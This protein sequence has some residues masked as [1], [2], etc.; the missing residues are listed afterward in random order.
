VFA[1]YHINHKSGISG[2]DAQQMVDITERQSDPTFRLLSYRALGSVQYFT[3][4]HRQALDT[5]RL[6]EGYRDPSKLNLPS[7]RFG[8]DP[9]LAVL[10]YK[11][12]ALME[13]GLLDQAK[14]VAEQVKV[15]L[16]DHAHPPTIAACTFF[17]VV[18]PE[19]LSGKAEECEQHSADL[20]AYCTKKKVA[21]F[22]L[23]AKLSLAC[24]RSMLKPT[25]ESIAAFRDAIKA[26]HATGAHLGD[27]F[28]FSNLAAALLKAGAVSEAAQTLQ[29]AFDFVERSGE[30]WWL[31]ELYR[32][33]G[34]V[35]LTQAEP[36]M[37][38]AEVAFLKAI[39]TA[40]QQE[41]RLHELRAV[42]ELAKLGCGNT[43]PRDCR[44]L[45]V[46]TLDMIEGG[47]EMREVCDARALLLDLA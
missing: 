24:A 23:F 35:K 26:Q 25:S 27:S 45:L 10:C 22:R 14:H 28:F 17:G 38:G 42:M 16:K 19:L 30:R 2:K 47:E 12:W 31:A 8:I 39:E 7:Y 21:Q 3:G 40:R 20:V 46:A 44:L 41:A 33:M 11:L 1:E 13:L 36:D 43:T 34:L 5:L 9:G 4:R 18:W 32:L 6:A 29:C 15:E 37:Q